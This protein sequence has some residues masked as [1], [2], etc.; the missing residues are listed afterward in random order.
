M[1]DVL[2]CCLGVSPS[3]AHSITAS[4]THAPAKHSC[5]PTS[6]AFITTSTNSSRQC[7]RGPIGCW[8]H[9]GTREVAGSWNTTFNNAKRSQRYSTAALSTTASS[10]SCGLLPAFTSTRRQ[11]FHPNRTPKS[12]PVYSGADSAA[13]LSHASA[14]ACFTVHRSEPLPT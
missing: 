1:E 2:T 12:L 4:A 13:F 5:C 6:T 8:R 3:G 10:Q 9:H 7:H 11:L 14:A